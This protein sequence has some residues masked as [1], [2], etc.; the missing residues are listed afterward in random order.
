[1]SRLAADALRY[2]L[3]TGRTLFADLSLGF[4]EERAALV[5]RNGTGKSTLAR[6]L[7]GVIAPTTGTVVRQGRVAYLAQQAEAPEH[8]SVATLLGIG[9]ALAALERLDAGEGGAH[10]VEA[11]GDRWDLRERAQRVLARVGLGA[12]PLEQRARA[13]SGGERTQIGRAHV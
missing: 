3:P 10:D 13:L 6:I 7:A 1:M 11:V 8:G 5:G 9:E 4:G 12:L 2:T